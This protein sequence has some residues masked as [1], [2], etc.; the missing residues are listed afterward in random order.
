MD[1]VTVGAVLLA[2]ATGVSEALGGQLWAG[3]VSLVRRPLHGRREPAEELPMAGSGESELAA[4]KGSP[5]DQAKAVALAEVLLAR[6]G[7]DP[8]FER[9]L[10]EWWVRAEPIREKLGNVTNTVSGG[11]QYGPVLQGRDFTG[12]TFG[13]APPPPARP[14]EPEAGLVTGESAGEVTNSVSG[15]NQYGPVLQAREI[16]NPTFVTNQTP[17]APMALAQL[18][19]L[20][21]GFTGR[22]SELAQVAAVLDPAG[23]VGAVVVSAVAGLAGVGKTALAIHAAHAALSSGWFPGGVLFIDLHGYDD[24]PVQPGQ[25]LDGLLRALGVPGEHIPDGAEQRAGLYR[26]ALAQ[27]TGPV[28]VIADNASAEAQVRPLIPGPGPH[29]VI[30]TSRHTLAGLGARLLDVTVLDQAAAVNLLDKVVR[31]GRPDDDRIRGVPAAAGRMAG[32]CCGL[33]LAPQITAALLAAD[34]ALTAAELAAE[35]ADEVRRLQALRY[36]DGSGVSALSVAAA[37]ELS[38]RQLEDDAARMF[39]LL[40]ADPGPDVST[41]AA[42]ELAGWPASRARAAIGRLTRAHLVEPGGA[43]GRWRMHDL[44]RLYAGQVPGNDPGEREQ[45]VDRLLAWY[46][47]QADAA[48]KHLWALAGTPVPAEFADRDDALAWLDAQ[49]PN[50]IA[51][52]T[53]AADTGRNQEAMDL[54]LTLSTYLDWRRRFDD[55]LTVLAVSRDSARQLNRRDSEAAALNNLG[56]A[57]WA[58]RRFEEAISAHQDAAA[59]F[60]QTG[61]RHS[62]G[63]VLNNLGTALRAVRRFEEAISAHEDAAAI[64][65]ETGDQYREGRVLSNLG[66][67]LR[68]VRRFEEAI[69]AHEDAAAI[70]RETGDRHSE[71]QAL[72]N[73]GTALREVRRFEEAI[74]AHEDA[75][76]IFRETGDRHSEGQALNNLGLALQKVRRFDEA[77]SACQGAA[78]IFRQAGD[79]HSEGAALNNL[80]AVLWEMRRFDEAISAHQ[81][82]AAIFRETGDLYSE[83]IAIR[84]VE[85]DRAAQTAEIA[86]QT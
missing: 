18:P 76:A 71:G 36:D 34:P 21:V 19:P 57:L 59:I 11:N 66:V 84:N 38:Y 45:A 63:R 65:R 69:S 30:I 48:D 64:F 68:E 37:F 6:A 29:R 54:P 82:A 39:R 9:A 8:G 78:A 81:G 58:V 79:R 61:D 86:D 62:E 32:G 26:S 12:L 25:A 17:A 23:G 49:R 14:K 10:Q 56:L 47:Q 53:M 85:R 80:A 31:A 2:V 60:L 44:L 72:N 42:A 16:V 75:V 3:V 41:G 77:I 70:F 74:S 51:A 15:G 52:V 7:G 73:L 43:R 40:P 27:V 46:L 5:G 50:L 13:A 1:P 67:A 24:S 35:M 83:E 28:L 55:W 33:S 22:D 4:L 20:A